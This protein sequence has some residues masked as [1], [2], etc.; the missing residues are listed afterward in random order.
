MGKRYKLSSEAIATFVAGHA[1]WRDEGGA[2]SRTFAFKDY[3]A[4]VAF[5]VRLAF[6]AE[7]RDH[8][9]DIHITWGKVRV[10]WSTHDA[11]GVT[12]LDAE[13]AE[14]TESLYKAG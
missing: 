14:V 7:K 3:G 12:D 10:D 9:P 11:G 6:A 4:G 13:M 1:E 8:H 2:I 5:A